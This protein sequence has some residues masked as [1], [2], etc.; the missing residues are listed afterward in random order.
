MLFLCFVGIPRCSHFAT[1]LFFFNSDQMLNGTIEDSN[2]VIR[3][4]FKQKYRVANGR[5]RPA[6]VQQLIHDVLAQKLAQQAYNADAVSNL[7]KEVADSIKT[8]LKG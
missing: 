7:T 1:R 5:F 3:P 8:Q 2:Y 4:N 6:K